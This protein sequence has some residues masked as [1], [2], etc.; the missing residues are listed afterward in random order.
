[1]RLR[2]PHAGP[3]AHVVV[4]GWRDRVDFPSPPEWIAG[5]EHATDER[6]GVLRELVRSEPDVGGS[7]LPTVGWT[8]RLALSEPDPIEFVNRSG[9]R[10]H[11]FGLFAPEHPSLALFE[12]GRIVAFGSPACAERLRARLPDLAP[13][14]IEQLDIRAERHP[15]MAADGAS[16]L[17]RPY[18]D[19]VVRD[20]GDRAHS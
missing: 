8:A 16:L 18:F 5:F 3:D 20:H 6:V 4:P 11:A 13:L 2:G 9:E 12:A 17:E 19:L 10:H 15:A 14:R 7:P 1:M